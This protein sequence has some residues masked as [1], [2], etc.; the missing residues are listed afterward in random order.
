MAQDDVRNF[1]KKR[2]ARELGH[3]IDR[4]LSLA[5]ISLNVAISLSELDPFYIE[6]LV[7]AQNSI[8]R[9]EFV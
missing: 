5:R 4:D 9:S 1:M 6:C 2:F 7:H 8:Q 3:G